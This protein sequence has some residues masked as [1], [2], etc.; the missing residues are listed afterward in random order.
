MS[1]SLPIQRPAPELVLLDDDLLTLEIV[2]WNT[3]KTDYVVHLFHDTEQALLHLQETPPQLLIVDYYMPSMTGLQ[4][5]EKARHSSFLGN[6]TIFLCSSVAQDQLPDQ[7]SSSL[8]V[9]RLDKQSVCDRKLLTALL[10][11]HIY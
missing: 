2:S 1:A 10:E 6:S 8:D 7:L 9:G 4:F 3:R 5:L 11:T